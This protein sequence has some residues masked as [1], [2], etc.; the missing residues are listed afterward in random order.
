MNHIFN[1]T[2]FIL[3]E[4]SFI[5]KKD[6]LPF[7]FLRQKKILAIASIALSFLAACYLVRNLCISNKL[8]HLNAD[9]KLSAHL[10][11]KHDKGVSSSYQKNENVLK[12]P[13]P[14]SNKPAESPK[15]D[16]EK[17]ILADGTIQLGKFKN[18]QL[19][20]YGKIIF[21]NGQICKGMFKN[22]QL[23]GQAKVIFPNGKIFEGIF[24]NQQLNG[25]GKI[26]FSNG[27]IDEGIFKD[28]KLHG[29]GKVKF[30]NGQSWDG[31][32]E[33]NELVEGTVLADDQIWE[34][35]FKD[36]K[37]HGSGKK[38]FP[39]GQILSGNFQKG[40]LQKSD[41]IQ[42]PTTK[43]Q[44]QLKKAA[45]PQYI[46]EEDLETLLEK[47]GPSATGITENYVWY[48]RTL[49]FGFS[50][51]QKNSFEELKKASDLQLNHIQK[52]FQGGDPGLNM[53]YITFCLEKLM[54]EK[55]R[56]IHTE[57]S[58]K[59]LQRL[60]S[61]L[62]RS[63]PFAFVS[64][65]KGDDPKYNENLALLVSQMSQELKQMQP[66][67]RL[68][69]PTGVH[70]H[71][72]LLILQKKDDGCIE[73]IY[74][75][76]G[77]G[78]DSHLTKNLSLKAITDHLNSF[79]YD[80]YPISKT[81][82]SIQLS[83]QKTIFESLMV[84]VLKLRNKPEDPV[85][86]TALLEDTLGNGTAGPAKP[87]QKNEVCSF[88]VLTEGIKD[89]LGSKIYYTTYKI[90][91]LTLMQEEFREITNEMKALVDREDVKELKRIYPLHVLLLEENQKQI[92]TAKKVLI[93]ANEC[94]K[95]S[96]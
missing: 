55:E 83:T 81:Y 53:T 95:N 74:Y 54:A 45:S 26:T 63:L 21:P 89:I 92:Q 78:V 34:G 68:L 3:K 85:K 1:N 38:T 37:L 58:L 7:L 69:I 82:P 75:N 29:R 18:D 15:H 2:S 56:N 79:L 96:F 30:P 12:S 16:D 46:P 43:K 62:Q 14:S 70:E 93:K 17:R 8:F 64:H 71:A 76:T 5:L 80:Y 32:F 40:R 88:Q 23:E 47:L 35:K 91:L 49:L 48:M 9:K 36:N 94:F 73:P 25:Q 11:V 65:M 39:S 90:D 44:V 84:K 31:I 33:D 60:H 86:I 13:S 6:L 77:L 20:G 66:N 87:I 61:D 50:F 28:G 4:N 42:I 51:G 41:K 19:E 24:K 27:Q 52:M 72:T 22:N 57:G 67:E 10:N 59:S